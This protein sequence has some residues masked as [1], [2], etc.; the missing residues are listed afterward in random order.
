MA[1]ILPRLYAILDP[2]QTKGRAPQIVLEGLLNGGVQ[3]LQLRVKALTPVDFLTLA[4][5]VRARTRAAGCQ[6]IVND[7]ID[8]ALAC[9]ADGGVCRDRAPRHPGHV[10]A[11]RSAA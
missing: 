2:E 8:I 4:T 7:R 10:P 11:R 5:Q 1:L 9:D 3:M 6:L